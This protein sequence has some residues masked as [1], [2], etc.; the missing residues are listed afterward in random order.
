MGTRKGGAKL[1][2]SD[3]AAKAKTGKTWVE[4]FRLLDKW[5]A[6][7]K[8]HREIAQ[9]L[10]RE[11]KA[12]SW[13]SQMLTVG[14][15]RARGRRAVHQTAQGYSASRSR[16]FSVPVAELYACWKDAATRRTWLRAGKFA[17]TSTK[18][19][20]SVRG[21][22][23]G[24]KG[25]VEVMFYAKGAGKSQLSVEQRKLANAAQVRKMKR[26]WGEQLDRLEKRLEA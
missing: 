24:G 10:A 6:A 2:T 8:T 4:W 1:P 11:H 15:E 12:P 18:L 21:T 25:A 20:R 23:D 14:Y 3:A 22:W 13:W 26:F 19:D 16:V 9:Y 5:G 17:V 7:A